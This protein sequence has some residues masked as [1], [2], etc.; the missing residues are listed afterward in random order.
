MKFP[1]FRVGLLFAALFVMCFAFRGIFAMDETLD[2]LRREDE[3]AAK[4]PKALRERRA[5]KNNAT[6][7]LPDILKRL[8]AVEKK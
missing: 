5:A 3:V 6:P 8:Q 4:Q 2:G 1:T 7:N